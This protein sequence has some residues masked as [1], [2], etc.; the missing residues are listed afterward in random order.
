MKKYSVNNE[1]MADHRMVE[2]YLASDVEKLLKTNKEPVAKLHCSDGLDD[3]VIKDLKRWQ[4]ACEKMSKM[5]YAIL[6]AVGYLDDNEL[7]QIG[8][9]SIIHK[10]LR[11]AIKGV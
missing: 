6:E 7:N 10:N 9:E 5:K 4:E 11:E 1:G 2:Y 3:P 8:S